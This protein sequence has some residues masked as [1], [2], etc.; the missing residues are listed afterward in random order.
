MGSIA[1]SIT[2]VSERASVPCLDRFRRSIVRG[3]QPPLADAARRLI[4]TLFF[5]LS[6]AAVIHPATQLT[7]PVRPVKDR[8]KF[9]AEQ[10]AGSDPG[11]P[12]CAPSRS[13]VRGI[14]K[15]ITRARASD[16]LCSSIHAS[17]RIR[18]LRWRLFHLW[19]RL[20]PAPTHQRAAL[21]P[22]SAV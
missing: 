14:Q 22:V 6:H 20:H 3:H 21:D 13:M 16:H 11:Y 7:L 19:R 1:S 9:M 2:V 18:T 8:T 10:N 17:L 12:T 4:L 15:L 5:H